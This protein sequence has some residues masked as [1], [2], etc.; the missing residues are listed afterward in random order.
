M[1]TKEALIVF[2]PRNKD[3]GNYT[4]ILVEPEL[5]ENMLERLN[6]RLVRPLN[7]EYVNS[8]IE[9]VSIE[10]GEQCIKDQ[11]ALNF[12][13]RGTND[14]MRAYNEKLRVEAHKGNK[15]QVLRQYLRTLHTMLEYLE[16]EHEN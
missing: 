15:R 4:F 1:S 9:L 6:A 11:Q 16:N 14:Y 8:C 2:H 13:E 10:L 7:V 3:G 5:K 12:F